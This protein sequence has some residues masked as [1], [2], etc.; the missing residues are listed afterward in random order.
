MKRRE[1]WTLSDETKRIYTERMQKIS[2]EDLAVVRKDIG[3]SSTFQ[4]LFDMRIG[5]D[6]I[7]RWSR[8]RLLKKGK[9]L[10]SNSKMIFVVIGKIKKVYRGNILEQDSQMFK[11]EQQQPA[12]KPIITRE[13]T[14]M[15]LLEVR[16]FEEIAEKMLDEKLENERGYILTGIEDSVVMFVHQNI[17]RDMIALKNKLLYDNHCT[18]LYNSLMELVPYP[19]ILDIGRSFTAIEKRRGD[20]IYEIGEMSD[21]FFIVKKGEVDVIEDVAQEVLRDEDYIARTVRPYMAEYPNYRQRVIFRAF[22]GDVFGDVEFSL[23]KPR[24]SRAVVFT[25]E[26][27]IYEIDRSMYQKLCDLEGSLKKDLRNVADAKQNTREV[28]KQKQKD[29]LERHQHESDLLQCPLF[30]TKVMREEIQ[31]Y[32]SPKHPVSMLNPTIKT[33]EDYKVS[34]TPN[35]EI[36]IF[37]K[38]N[39][40]GRVRNRIPLYKLPSE[41]VN[42][43]KMNVSDNQKILDKIFMT[44]IAKDRL[45]NPRTKRQKEKSLH[46]RR[47]HS[48]YSIL[49]K[50]VDPTSKPETSAP[51]RTTKDTVSVNDSSSITINHNNLSYRIGALSNLESD[52]I[53]MN[54]NSKRNKLKEL[55]QYKKSKPLK[56]DELSL[57]FDEDARRRRDVDEIFNTLHVN[58]IFSS[59][60]HQRDLSNSKS[61]FPPILLT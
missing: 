24:Y 29:T 41:Q 17:F 30:K 45:N 42:G 5:L 51:F 59:H 27:E 48:D 36:S 38:Q 10:I 33:P 52:R 18:F 37:I 6:H 44:T 32:R 55:V 26:A 7:I 60:H 28:M 35:E 8:F 11:A 53:R 49:G 1:E 58:K 54:S 50:Q 56:L 39:L 47:D 61:I 22:L 31:L 3:N 20:V 12:K 9:S 16:E 43:V 25:S 19:H 46:E 23:E 14:K 2:K 34:K 21:S 40:I 15:N 13:R 4:E 57:V